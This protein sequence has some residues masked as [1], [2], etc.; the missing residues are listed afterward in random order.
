MVL[1]LCCI[2]SLI[3][4]LQVG[5]EVRFALWIHDTWKVCPHSKGSGFWTLV[6]PSKHMAQSLSSWVPV[7]DPSQGLPAKV[8]VGTGGLMGDRGE[9]VRVGA[10]WFG[11]G[12][13]C[14]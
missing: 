13:L 2:G 10:D 14:R 11:L 4:R 5:Q 9:V 3:S 8:L 12:S 1:I 7:S 6:I